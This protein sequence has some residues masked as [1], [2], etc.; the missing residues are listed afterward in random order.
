MWCKGRYR[1]WQCN[2]KVE[3]LE[4]TVFE[5]VSTNFKVPSVIDLLAGGNDGVHGP[6]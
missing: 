1:F 6:K 5:A 2:R 4:N 3:K